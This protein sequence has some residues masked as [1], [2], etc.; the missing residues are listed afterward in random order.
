MS[1]SRR[2]AIAASGI[3][4]LSALLS[5]TAPAR[6]TSAPVCADSHPSAGVN[7]TLCLVTPVNGDVLGSDAVVSA[8]V[9]V[10]NDKPVKYLSF[11]LDG[12]GPGHHL[13]ADFYPPY[14]F[15][16]PTS[17]WADGPHT[18]MA[19]AVIA[20]SP[21]YTTPAISQS[22]TF[23]AGGPI[24]LPSDFVPRSGSTP[25]VG[26][27]FVVAAVGDGADGGPD[28]QAVVSLVDGWAPNLFL[29]LGDV[30]EQGAFSEF[31]NWYGS[32]DSYSLFAPI[33]DPTIG[34]H[35]YNT[36]SP[37]AYFS[38]WHQPPHYYSVNAGG[39]H[40]ISLDST[41]DFLQD[42]PGTVQYEWLKNDLSTNTSACTMVFFH[43]PTWSNGTIGASHG[44]VG[45]PWMSDVW[46]LLA[47]H[48]VDIV[49][50]GHDH[51][52]Q[53]WLALGPTG[54]PD[55]SGPTEFVVGTGGHGLAPLSAPVPRV[56]AQFDTVA[57]GALNLA[58][59]PG[60]AQFSFVA[61]PGVVED[62]GSITCSPGPDTQKPTT[63]TDLMATVVG[64][65]K[66]DLGWTASSDAVG[67]DRYD[68]SRDGT[69]IGTAPG[70]VTSFP[71]STVSPNTAYSYRVVAVDAAGNRS[72]PSDPAVAVT[73]ASGDTSA[74]TTPTDLTAT[75]TGTDR[76]HLSWS[77]SSDDAGVTGYEVV[78]DGGPIR[79]VPGTS[80]DD[81]GLVPGTSH[82]YTVVA[83]DQ[84]GNHSDPATTQGRAVGF[85]DDLESGTLSS[86]ATVS[87]AAVG[88]DP[89]HTGSWA[90]QTQSAGSGTSY[91]QTPLLGTP[92]NFYVSAWVDVLS[93]STAVDLL[94]LRHQD[95]SGIVRVL[96]NS[97]GM[98][99]VRNETT[100]KTYATSTAWTNGSW[101]RVGL[102]V[103]VSGT[104]SLIEV[105]VDGAL[106][107]SKLKSLGSAPIGQLMVGDSAGRR[108]YSV[109]Y[110][111]VEADTVPIA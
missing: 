109:A 85:F 93:R 11:T 110:D 56:A 45:A 20:T 61:A 82:T 81:V 70:L 35:E 83:R 25:D 99:A 22:V 100:G 10:S 6:A 14:T 47:S 15:T 103:T 65:S 51:N 16:L 18:L 40:L 55:L 37:A 27:P 98:V 71:D 75:A 96:L 111:D 76:I 105:S 19:K 12:S 7:V 39:W 88:P 50:N 48:G 21:V 80:F 87:G 57:A 13:L 49:L 53:R 43:H 36:G 26:Q 67:V 107:Y 41:T 46:S 74:P 106:V 72:D 101:H 44:G 62:S 69:L 68:I 58:L 86:W 90:L 66:I 38:F 60:S 64:S 92:S 59:Y 52:Y 9:T 28:S 84:A 1:P 31:T 54:A 5:L 29:Y 4:C 89:V 104:S 3:A 73:D 78:T 8:N 30:Y 77:P 91:V 17:H 2:L 94:R 108:T 32:G 24:T 42:Q 34:N 63:P 95:N 97:A 33:T 79:T 102:H 23:A